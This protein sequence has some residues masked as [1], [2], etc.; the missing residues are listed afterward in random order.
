MTLLELTIAAA[1][2][3]S[4]LVFILGSIVS[5]STTSDIA[6]DQAATMAYVSTIVEELRTASGGD[7]LGYS[8]PAPPA[9]SPEQ[10]VEIQY[11]MNGDGATLSPPIVEDESPPDLPNP[12]HITISVTA[13]S[14]SGRHFTTKTATMLRR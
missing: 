6:A 7:L 4:T 12:L 9:G 5:L 3:A 13:L 2:L 8:P 14:K 1:I 10:T 11:V